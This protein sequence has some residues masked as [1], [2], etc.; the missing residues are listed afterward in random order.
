MHGE[1]A[2]GDVAGVL[3]AAAAILLVAVPIAMR[4]YRRER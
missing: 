1:P 3:I 4:L 2:M